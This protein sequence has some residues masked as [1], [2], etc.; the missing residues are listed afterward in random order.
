[1]CAPPWTASCRPDD[2]FCPVETR[3]FAPLDDGD[4]LD[5]GGLHAQALAFPG[6]TQ[7][8]MAVLLPELETALLGDACN[9]RVYLFGPWAS[10]VADYRASADHFR[11]TYAHLYRQALVSHGAFALCGPGHPEQLRDPVRADP[12]RHGR[13]ASPAPRSACRSTLPSANAAPACA[14][15]AASATSST[16]G[17]RSDAPVPCIENNR[18]ACQTAGPAALCFFG[19]L[20]CVRSSRPTARRSCRWGPYR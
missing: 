12:G 10:T 11:H 4:T 6:H 1:M 5:L 9:T 14:P 15:T 3:S 20:L 2:A 17:T 16:G 8:S 13:P 19:A 18:G 7:G